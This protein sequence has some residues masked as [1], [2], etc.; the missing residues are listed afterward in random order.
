MN[1]RCCFVCGTV[2]PRMAKCAGCKMLYYCSKKC[3]KAHYPTHK[4]ECTKPTS[5]HEAICKAMKE[6]LKRQD[7]SILLGEIANVLFSL[8]PAKKK[9]CNMIFKV[10]DDKKFVLHA[11]EVLGPGDNSNKMIAAIF[12]SLG[13]TPI[14][15][16]IEGFTH[17]MFLSHDLQP[18]RAPLHLLKKELNSLLQ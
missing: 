11:M 14:M 16:N 1:E 17:T 4:N 18:P 6:L 5:H 10:A 13:D 7:V 9:A 8:S 12:K 2:A 15:I 3:Q